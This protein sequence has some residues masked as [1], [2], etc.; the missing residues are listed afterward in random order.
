MFGIG[1]GEAAIILAVALLLVR[2]EDLP[3]LARRLGRI[4]ASLK[5]LLRAFNA[6]EAEKSGS[7]EDRDDRLE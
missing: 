7:K 1:L 3:G 5:E 2:P 6:D 4:R